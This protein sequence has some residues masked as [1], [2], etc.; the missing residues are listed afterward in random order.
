MRLYRWIKNRS[1]K[2]GIP[3]YHYMVFARCERCGEAIRAHIDLR[4]DLS[5]QYG[6]EGQADHY[7]IRKTIIGSGLC[8]NPIEVE[9][10]FDVKRNLTHQSINGGTFICEEEFLDG[11]R[12]TATIDQ[13]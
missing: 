12:S 3:V 9:L 8:F 4:N 13:D 5:I 2:G 6:E 10:T 11:S 7:F 1:Q